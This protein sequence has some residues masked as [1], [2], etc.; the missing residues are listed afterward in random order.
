MVE[1]NWKDLERGCLVWNFSSETFGKRFPVGGSGGTPGHCEQRQRS[2]SAESSRAGES[3]Q[4]GR[5]SQ[6]RKAGVGVLHLPL[7]VFDPGRLFQA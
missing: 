6:E 7:K 4:R 2:E 5:E 3:T 1:G